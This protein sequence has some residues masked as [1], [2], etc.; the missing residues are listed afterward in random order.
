M[1]AAAMTP[2][3][4]EHESLE[5]LFLRDSLHS[6]PSA[7]RIQAAFRRGA[8]GRAIPAIWMK[9]AVERV[10]AGFAL[11]DI[12]EEFCTARPLDV[13]WA[14]YMPKDL[15]EDQPPS[16]TRHAFFAAARSDGHPIA[17][18]SKH[19]AMLPEVVAR[20]GQRKGKLERNL[21]KRVDRYQELLA[22]RTAAMAALEENDAARKPRGSRPRQV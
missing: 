5:P 20:N 1:F 12:L 10:Q 15:P 6:V 19:Y 13:D 3:A 7:R 17:T 16:V 21:E 11:G 8:S 22:K 18:I 2:T 9:R 14:A 4:A